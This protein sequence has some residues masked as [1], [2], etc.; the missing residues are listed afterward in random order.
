VFHFINSIKNIK[1]Y[2]IDMLSRVRPHLSFSSP[3][4]PPFG[5]LLLKEKEKGKRILFEETVLWCNAMLFVLP[6]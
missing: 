1:N 5:H 4:H 6:L 2:R 3:P